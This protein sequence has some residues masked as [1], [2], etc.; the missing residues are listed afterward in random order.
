MNKD[1]FED[2]FGQND[3]L[4]LVHNPLPSSRRFTLLPIQAEQ[5]VK[6]L[7]LIRNLEKERADKA[8]AEKLTGASA[9]ANAVSNSIGYF[10]AFLKKK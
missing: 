4:F 9:A 7:Q 8:E 2:H 6:E 10:S 5:S 3:N 1:N